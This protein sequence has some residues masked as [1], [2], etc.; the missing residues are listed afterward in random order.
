MTIPSFVA[1]DFETCNRARSS[2]I[3]IG[4]TRVVDGV[5][6]A[7]QVSPVMPPIGF[8]EFEPGL[9][10]IHGLD[11]S[12]VHGAPEWDEVHERL[13][14]Y[15]GDLPLVAHSASFERSVINQTSATLGFVAHSFD[16][17][18][19]L[20]MARTLDKAAPNHKLNTLA[21]RYGIEQL[22]HHDAGDDSLVGARLALHLL[23][24]PGGEA[25]FEKAKLK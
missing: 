23:A 1:I 15:V 10:K 6:R 8:R 13:V 19:T 16:I 7:P 24:Q 11:P 14:R 18:C 21:D 22:A 2:P 25:A 20:S 4:L 17:H 3:Q 9:I 12:Y 5:P